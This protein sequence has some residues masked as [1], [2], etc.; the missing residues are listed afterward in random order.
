[1]ALSE[2]L[3]VAL[4][5]LIILIFHT[6]IQSQNADRRLAIT[7]GNLTFTL[8]TITN[9]STYSPKN[10]VAIWI[11][12]AQGNFV[13]SRKVMADKRKQHLVKW[14]ASSLGNTVSATTGATLTSHQAHTITW[15]G[16]NAAGT[17][18]ADG[19]Y[20]IWIEYV[21]TNAASN[22]NQGPSLSVEFTKGKAA[23]HLNPANTTYYQNIVADWVPLSTG[24]NK[25]S[26]AGANVKIYP[27]PFSSETSIKLIC[28]KPSQV[29]ICAFDASGKKVSELLN[30]SFGSG[31]RIYTW[32][33][34]SDKGQNLKNGIYFVQIQI[35]G[36][37]E[38][39]KV[40]IKR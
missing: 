17:D 16:K 1:M 22:G 30:D 36:Y 2:K 11:K 8:K 26:N 40:I 7:P 21:S 13:V 20:Q 24:L 31:T 15:D 38:L 5:S 14:N 9:G 33:G 28:D 18:M 12:D 4:T 6:T 32:D 29:Y 37:T 34:K 23:Q 10:V 25:L 19:I 3:Q 27:N 35:N 39:Q